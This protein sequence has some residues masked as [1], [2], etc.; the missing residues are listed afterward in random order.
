MIQEIMTEPEQLVYSWLTQRKIP[1]QT[2]V[3]MFGGV[4]EAGGAKIDFV[5]QEENIIIRVM[6]YWHS[7]GPALARDR[8]QKIALINDGW[9]VVDVQ[10]E[11]LKEN[12]NLV[13]N[14]ALRG[15]EIP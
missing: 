7:V 8:L 12:L 10:E 4:T 3:N 5:L 6:S 9:T 15:E 14:K 2:Q 11:D 1:F 13:M